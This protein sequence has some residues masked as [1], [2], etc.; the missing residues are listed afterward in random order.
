YNNLLL[1]DGIP[2]NNSIFRAG[3]NQ[4]WNT[5]DALSL[6]RLEVL[7]GP[8]SA[9][10]GS[11]AMGGVVNLYTK[12]P[13]GEQGQP[14]GRLIYEHSDAGNFH[15]MR[16]ENSFVGKSTSA[17]IGLTVKDFGDVEGGA[18]VGLQPGTGYDETDADLKV[19]HWLDDHSLLIFGH[20]RVN[21]NNVP[22]THSTVN[23]IDWEGLNHGSDLVRNLD[24]D[25]DLTYLQLHR[26]G[27]DGLFDA[28]TTSLSWHNQSEERHRIRSSMAEEFQGL[29]V[30]TLGFFHHMYRETDHGQWTYGVDY[31][32]D[33]VSSFLDKGAA[34]TPADDIQGPVAD[35]ATYQT[36]HIFA[37]DRF[38]VSEKTHLI[39]G[40][41]FSR[42]DVDANE[43]RDP[44]TD[45][46]TS[47]S[48]SYDATAVSL[49][50]ES[51]LSEKNRLELYG[52]IS[53]GYRLPNL[54]D[55][56]RFD[57]AR[58]GEFEVPSPGL[59]PEKVTGIDLGVRR[60]EGRARYD[61]SAFY[62]GI[63]DGIQRF[64]TGT[65]NGSGD[66]EITKANI[67]DGHIWGWVGLLDLDMTP[68]W[69][70]HL[71]AAYQ[72]GVQDTYPTSA[73]VI[74]S[75]PIDRLMPF[76][77]HA[78]LR[79]QAPSKEGWGELMLTHAS[80]ADRLSTRDEADTQRIPAGGTPGYSVVDLRFGKSF[81]KNAD[82]MIGV[83][84]IF[85]ED[86]R[87]HGSGVNRPGR[88]LVFGLIMRF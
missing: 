28:T 87:I 43:V 79:W 33:W 2:L 29:D 55:L 31:S 8:N 49:Q 63:Q 24:Q 10:Y 64:P 59:D 52:G 18:D 88:G 73:P 71:D 41:G 39:A 20:Q 76:T 45:L 35:D 75:E 84:N 53:Q 46:Q 34:Q 14:E 30:G 62:T 56:S 23:G 67:G 15:I 58:S 51:L 38:P 37:Q 80:K 65:V 5:V 22:R 68:T 12:S 25:R 50:F 44:V 77:M 26:E 86:Y 40:V 82:V 85:D 66:A 70:L 27:L 1:I 21:Q 60:T 72:Y 7:L 3:P 78:G 57:T 17:L 47:I 11:G 74:E 36:I 83:E 9:R 54:S 42:A 6:E 69:T 48:E 19:E 4:Y 16:V 81:H 32:R 13:Y 61:L